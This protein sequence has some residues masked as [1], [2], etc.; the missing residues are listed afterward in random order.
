MFSPFK[1]HAHRHILDQNCP[2]KARDIFSLIWRQK[3]VRKKVDRSSLQSLSLTLVKA[4]KQQQ[5]PKDAQKQQKQRSQQPLS[6]RGVSKQKRN[7]HFR[8]RRRGE[9]VEQ[10]GPKRSEENLCNG[11]IHD[12]DALLVRVQILETNRKA[13]R[14]RVEAS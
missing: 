14:T 5:Q 8:E 6:V 4:E 2:H 13:N 9:N 12:R 3:C 11:R 1:R 10:F 7:R